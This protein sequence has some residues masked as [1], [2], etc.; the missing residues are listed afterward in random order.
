MW[1][2]DEIFVYLLVITNL[3][4]LQVFLILNNIFSIY[5]DDDMRVLK[6]IIDMDI[7]QI[8]LH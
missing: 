3:T 1:H 2:L 7:W 4:F 6:Q 5:I 8:I